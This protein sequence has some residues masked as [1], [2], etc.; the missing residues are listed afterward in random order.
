MHLY[1]QSAFWQNAS[2]SDG[3]SSISLVTD[4][5][6]NIYNATSDNGI[7]RSS[8]QGK[9]WEKISDRNG[10][11]LYLSSGDILFS[12]L[13]NSAKESYETTYSS[14]GGITWTPLNVVYN[15]AVIPIKSLACNPQNVIFA[16]TDKGLY[17]S[18]DNGSS[19]SPDI[20]F[21]KRSLLKIS[22]LNNE[23]LV[24][25]YVN[26]APGG[27]NLYISKSADDGKTW[28][29]FV[30]ERVVGDY[31]FLQASFAAGKSGKFYFR[32]IVKIGTFHSWDEYNTFAVFDNSGIEWK[33]TPSPNSIFFSSI[34]TDSS[35]N[36]LAGTTGNGILR[37]SDDGT[38]WGSVSAG[39]RNPMIGSLL[40]DSKNIIYAGTKGGVLFSDD[41]CTTWR[42][43]TSGLT[44]S[45]L[46]KIISDARGNL[47]VQ[48]DGIFISADRGKS[49][50][51]LNNGL[52]TTNI[53]ELVS[54]DKYVFT[55]IKEY[56]S[57]Y[58]FYSGYK[59]F[60]NE[61][62]WKK[63][64]VGITDVAAGLNG[65]IYAASNYYDFNP[66]NYD[67]FSSTDGGNTWTALPVPASVKEQKPLSITTNSK[68]ELYFNGEYSGIYKSSDN[69]Q[70]WT[71]LNFVQTKAKKIRFNARD[72]LFAQAD[73]YKLF[74][75][76]D[77]GQSWEQVNNNLPGYKIT[78]M[79]VKAG[80]IY[81]TLSNG[82]LYYSVNDGDTW[83]D[84]SYNLDTETITSVTDD[85]NSM[86]YVT[87]QR[88]EVYYLDK[89]FMTSDVEEAVV[90]CEYG[91]LQNFPN[92]FNP[93][94]N[95]GY[96]LAEPGNVRLSVYDILGNE[97]AVLVNEYKN[98]GIYSTEMDASK[99]SSGIYFYRLETGT[100]WAAKK[101]ILIK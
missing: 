5:K 75:S 84:I 23:L 89:S 20:L 56:W 53:V 60:E 79:Y 48:G 41:N 46:K 31:G 32:G 96:S 14:D 97:V 69:G 35:G 93:T 16:L 2:Y 17:V 76:K 49:W 10:S 52:P 36:V 7:L 51:A 9:S 30:T 1:S 63:V 73:D 47:Y 59:L 61:N 62:T 18:K 98:K 78:Y 3:G 26:I 37:S 87:T 68:G 82:H 13:Y 54:L 85:N 70:S 67:L 66:A 65:T 15:S 92:P 94:T 39:I 21:A 42:E 6:G 27:I 83:S 19:W 81:L 91:L 71:A 86:L 57:K 55:L 50:Y 34:I 72:Y 74:R 25:S 64:N 33:S 12:S 88:N 28:T 95:I 38:T 11:T 77:D 80:Q 101:M 100:Y 22:Y 90:P 24:C 43:L 44:V 4:S 40:R 29:E 99:L 58:R 8:D 45:S